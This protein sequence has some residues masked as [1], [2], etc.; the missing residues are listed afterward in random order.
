[1][2]TALSLQNTPAQSRPVKIRA[3]N[4]PWLQTVRHAR[5]RWLTALLG[6]A[7]VMDASDMFW[8]PTAIPPGQFAMAALAA[9]VVLNMALPIRGTRLFVVAL[10]LVMG[11][12]GLSTLITGNV[13]LSRLGTI[14]AWILLA[15]G[16]ARGVIS[17]GSLARGM[18]LG[19]VIAVGYGIVFL[20]SSSYEGRLTGLLGDPNT[21]GLSLASM[22]LLT[23]VFIKR[24][25]IRW[26][27]GIVVVLGL[28]LTASRT[29]MLAFAVA[30]LIVVCAHRLHPVIVVAAVWLTTWWLSGTTR[31][32]G[33]GHEF[34]ERGFFADREG[35]DHLRT[36]L[37]PLEE[38]KRVSG[39]LFGHGPGEAHIMLEEDFRMYVHNSYSGFQIEFGQLGI[40]AL[41][42]LA[43]V[44]LLYC[45]YRGAYRD[46][47]VSWSIASLS[48]ILVV[49]ISLGEAIVTPAGAVS[50]G[51][52]VLMARNARVPVK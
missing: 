18:A 50:I 25:W 19:L 48:A 37:A 9:L 23:L 4:N 31:S 20:G 17:L 52:I 32:G 36:L 47:M 34:F 22:G 7:L 16:V 28:V 44:L 8:W 13:V 35:S 15:Y 42:I 1:M 27:V 40:S 45:I 39:G 14:I 29:S 30:I 49:S 41:I 5:T 3:G 26:F 11:A 33:T 12:V 24:P 6:V 21:A 38:R 43:C 51:A 2:S 46:P 10:M